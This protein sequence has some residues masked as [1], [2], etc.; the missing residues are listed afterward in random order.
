MHISAFDLDHTLLKAN[1]SYQFGKYLFQKGHLTC[2]QVFY[3]ILCYG[4]HSVGLLSTQ[5]LHFLSFKTIFKAQSGVLFSG[6]VSEFLDVCLQGLLSIPVLEAFQ[7]AKQEGHYTAIFS[8]SPDFLVAPIADRLGFDLSVSTPYLVNASGFFVSVGTVMDGLKKA[9][10]LKALANH[11]QVTQENIYAYSDS[12]QDLPFMEAAGHPI[13]VRPDR[14]LK[15]IST[16]RGW[17]TLS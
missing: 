3:L 6:L 4:F 9:S 14:L 5:R 15:Y 1:C 17:A 2:F 13:A 8:N 7:K 11:L 12:H 16:R 10:A